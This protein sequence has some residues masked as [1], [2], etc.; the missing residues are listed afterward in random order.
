[1]VYKPV[2]SIPMAGLVDVPNEILFK[3]VAFLPSNRDIGNARLVS[4]RINDIAVEIL[5]S[6]VT[7]YAHPS[8][9]K[10]DD[11]A[12]NG[13]EDPALLEYDPQ[14]FMNILEHDVFKTYVKGVTIYTCET[15]C[16]S[17]SSSHSFYEV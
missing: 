3:I 6:N 15:H 16:V 5:F 2:C 7:L 1:M 8:P 14:M 12:G 17:K 13:D 11:D 10:D 4:R 9:N